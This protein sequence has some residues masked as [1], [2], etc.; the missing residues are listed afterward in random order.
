MSTNDGPPSGYASM[1]D[2]ERG[3]WDAAVERLNQ[4]ED[5]RLRRKI[6]AVTK[7]A[8]DKAAQAWSAVPKHDDIE[9]QILKALGGMKALSF[10]PALRSVNASKVLRRHGVG[11]AKD[12][13][14]LDLRQLDRSMPGLR[15]FYAGT[16]GLG[17]GASALAVTGAEVSST[18]SGGVTITVA[19]GAIAADV[20]SSM[21][22]LG[23]VIG[24]VAAEYGYDVRLPEEEAY[25]LGVMSLGAATTA[26]EKAAAL[27]SL[28]RLT[29]QMMRQATWAQLNNNGWV[30]L[31]KRVYLA[32][33]ERL[34]HRKLAQA[35]PVVGIAIN[36]GMS[37]QMVDSAYR[38]ARDVYRLRYLSEKYDLDPRT[39]TADQSGSHSD[40]DPLDDAMAE[41]S[42]H[43][44]EAEGGQREHLIPDDSHPITV[45][46][47]DGRV[48][49]T[50][51]GRVIAESDRALTLQE[52]SYPPVQYVPLADVDASVLE[53]TDH[54]TYCPYKGDASYYSLVDGDAR[55]ENVVWTY[56]A[57]YDAVAPI[58]GHVAFYPDE[59]EISVA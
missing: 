33:G 20:A 25:A 56:D 42:D 49:V 22:L 23:R 40:S 34:T 58:A 2:Y 21:A 10:D 13:H 38:S 35:V 37:A 59:V 14:G 46:S 28:R 8:K 6:G 54:A 4:K 12:L 50:R 5:S 27:A 43:A 57:P 19:A 16:A 29:S 47:T 51:H 31:I 7:P 3:A 44:V 39:W 18:V 48:V 55:A 41:L 45:T 15:T 17:G 52:A 11:S 53:R 26:A 32:L 24:R 36:A 30:V 1:S 9:K